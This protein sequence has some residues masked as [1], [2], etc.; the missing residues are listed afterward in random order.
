M[1]QVL[2]TGTCSQLAI[3]PNKFY[4]S[5][6]DP[7]NRVTNHILSLKNPDPKPDPTQ[8]ELYVIKNIYGTVSRVIDPIP[9]D[10]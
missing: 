10:L 3:L 2:P 7:Q 9:Y 1:Y 5:I 6:T 8:I 4:V